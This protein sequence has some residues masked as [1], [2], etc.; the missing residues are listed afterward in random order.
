MEAARIEVLERVMQRLIPVRSDVFLSLPELA[1]PSLQAPLRMLLDP[2][3]G[4]LLPLNEANHG[5]SDLDERPLLAADIRRGRKAHDQYQAD[6]CGNP[7]EK[8]PFA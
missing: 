5:S 1:A 4:Y 8:S 3:G 2:L 7:P 6:H